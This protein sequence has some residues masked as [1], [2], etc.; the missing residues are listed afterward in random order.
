M[1]S[2]DI[3]IVFCLRRISPVKIR[4]PCH[5]IGVAKWPHF[6]SYHCCTS[7]GNIPKLWGGQMY[8]ILV[9]YDFHVTDTKEALLE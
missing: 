2:L 6:H 7:G 5:F 4:S 8:F 9:S 1:R 3:A